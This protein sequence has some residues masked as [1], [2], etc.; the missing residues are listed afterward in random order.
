MNK[1]I[2]STNAKIYKCVRAKKYNTLECVD[3]IIKIVFP[4]EFRPLDDASNIYLFRFHFN[5]IVMS[6]NIISQHSHP[7]K[8]LLLIK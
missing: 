4:I 7:G 5:Y 3:F 8:I 6:Q 2:I 1:R